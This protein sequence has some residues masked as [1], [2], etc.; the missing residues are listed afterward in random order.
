MSGY[1]HIWTSYQQARQL[2]GPSGDAL[3]R[4]AEQTA[5]HAADDAMVLARQALEAESIAEALSLL[6]AAGLEAG[7]AQEVGW[8]WLFPA[9]NENGG[10]P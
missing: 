6:V 7:Q 10:N 3:R 1:R 2:G 5:R 9:C 4:S 8:P